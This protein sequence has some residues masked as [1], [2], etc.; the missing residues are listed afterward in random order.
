MTAL[1]R[2]L[3]D[4]KY[5]TRLPNFNN[6]PSVLSSIIIEVREMEDLIAMGVDPT[7]LSEREQEI[8]QQCVDELDQPR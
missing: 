4:L 1:S 6:W 5:D 8:C 3:R 7:G 2:R